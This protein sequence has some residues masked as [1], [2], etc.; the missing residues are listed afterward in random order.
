MS[1]KPALKPRWKWLRKLKGWNASRPTY[2][3]EMSGN[4]GREGFREDIGSLFKKVISK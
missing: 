4:Q 3:R 1:K 2:Y